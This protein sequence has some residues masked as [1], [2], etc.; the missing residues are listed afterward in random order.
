V[1]AVWFN[2]LPTDSVGEWNPEILS[3]WRVT[4]F[5]DAEGALGDW[6]GKHRDQMELGL[7]GGAVVWDAALVFGPE[8]MWDEIPH[9]LGGVRLYDH[10]RPSRAAAESRSHL[11]RQPDGVIPQPGPATSALWCQLG[12]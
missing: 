9:P 8:A 11:D 6:F 7:F 12:S 2:V 3:D 1:Y 4:E 5:W 10:R